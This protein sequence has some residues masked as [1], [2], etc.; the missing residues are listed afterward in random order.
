MNLPLSVPLEIIQQILNYLPVFHLIK[1]ETVSKQFMRIIRTSPWNHENCNT[2]DIKIMEHVIKNYKFTNYQLYESL[3]TDEVIKS[4][5]NCRT[6][7]LSSCRSFPIKNLGFLVDLVNLENLAIG[8]A[9]ALR[10]TDIACLT[11]LKKLDLSSTNITGMY[12][13]FLKKLEELNLVCAE[14]I[15]DENL[16]TLTNL[17]KLRI[18]Y[19]TITGSSFVSLINLETINIDRCTTITNENYSFLIN[20]RKCRFGCFLHPDRINSL[21][22]LTNPKKLAITSCENL[23]NGHLN[24]FTKLQKLVL[25]NCY[26]INDALS[27]LINL[28]ALC[29]TH[30]YDIVD[31]AL[32]FLVHLQKLKLCDCP[33]ITGSCFKFF[34]KLTELDIS[35]C[36]M[37]TNDSFAPLINLREL[38]VSHCPNITNITFLSDKTIEKL[39]LSLFSI[40][41]ILSDYHL[42]FF[43]NLYELKIVDCDT[44]RGT[45]FSSLKNLR[46]LFCWY[47]NGICLDNLLLLS[48]ECVVSIKD[49][50]WMI[51]RDAFIS[52]LKKLTK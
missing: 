20:L 1:T 32:N 28:H 40:R 26:N 14:N 24:S 13:A 2:R 46:K 52:D 39:S 15:T 22:F 3:M 11:N 6:I 23:T 34:D 12:F 38:S 31:A 47:C 10:D 5:T 45:C 44:I 50:D 49:C 33:T 19:V 25:W 8:F 43:E 4:I 27:P 21:K 9:T 18:D 42:N 41:D 7:K 16:G 17:K 48:D 51:S 29:L 30:C 36:E 37:I 35:S